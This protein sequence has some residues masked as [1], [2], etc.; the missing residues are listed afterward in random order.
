MIQEANSLTN[1]EIK[2][3]IK[4][5]E[6]QTSSWKGEVNKMRVD[7]SKITPFKYTFY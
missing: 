2:Q 1:D 3:R 4:A 7:M 6:A 5:L